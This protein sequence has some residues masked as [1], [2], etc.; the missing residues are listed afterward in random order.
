[1]KYFS[2]QNRFQ[3]VFR[4]FDNHI[5]SKPMKI[6]ISI[7]LVAVVALSAF[8]VKL[9]TASFYELKAKTIDGQ[10]FNFSDLKGKKVLV[11]NTAS[12][13]GFTPQYEFREVV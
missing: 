12:K 8:T 10:D 2:K 13:C 9:N 6:K 7:L 11:V 1:M 4:T 5:K 3:F